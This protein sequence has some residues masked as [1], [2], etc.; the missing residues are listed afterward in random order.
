MKTTKLLYLI[1]TALGLALVGAFAQTASSPS[2]GFNK[3]TCA[4]AA[5]T[6]ISV[7][8]HLKPEFVGV[9]SAA[10]TDATGGSVEAGENIVIE[11]SGTSWTNDSFVGSHFVRF[12]SGAK[13]GYYFE[14]FANTSNTLTLDSNGADLIGIALADQVSLIPHNTLGNLF[15]DGNGVNPSTSGFIRNT[16]IFFPSAAIGINKGSA[17]TYF[18]NSTSSRWESFPPDGNKDNVVVSPHSVMIVRNNTGETQI[19][20]SGRVPSAKHAVQI[21]IGT[22][23]NDVFFSIDRPIPVSLEDSG[24]EVGGAFATSANGFVRAD[25]LFVL[26]SGQKNAGAAKIYFLVT[27]VDGGDSGWR[28][29]PNPTNDVGSDVVFE[30]GEA[31]IIRKD[32]AGVDATVFGVNAPTY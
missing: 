6:L 21:D 7:P 5:D 31:V 11:V 15:P 4:A 10:P 2:I 25:E 24:L 26:S 23:A 1:P 20:F 18:Y 30:P 12:T 9:L 29:F 16:E 14:V 19:C 13:D 3:V 28:L 17:A 22:A 32:A 27:P 8:F